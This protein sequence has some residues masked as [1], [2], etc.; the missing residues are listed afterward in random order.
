MENLAE[1]VAKLDALHVDIQPYRPLKPEQM[2]RLMQKLRLDW[3]YHSNHIEGNSLT[4]G[5][6]RTLLL[7]GTTAK[8]KPLKDHLDIQGHNE[9]VEWIM[10][11]LRGEEVERPL[12]ETFIRELHKLILKEPYYKDAITSN[13]LPTKKLIQIG[14][15]KTE[16]N[17]VLTPTGEMFYYASPEE[18]QARM[19]YLMTWYETETKKKE[20][21]PLAIA[22]GFHYRFVRIHPFDDG[23]GRMARLLMNFILMKYGY[24]PAIIPTEQRKEY[25]D[26]L[27]EADEIYNENEHENTSYL[28]PLAIYVGKCLTHSLDLMLKVARGESIEEP[29]DFSKKV[30]LLQARIKANEEIKI[31]KDENVLT[32]LIHFELSKNVKDKIFYKK[33]KELAPLFMECSTSII[34]PDFDNSKLLSDI[35]DIP[36]IKIL[37]YKLS[38]SPDFDFTQKMQKKY[39]NYIEYKFYL[40]NFKK[41]GIKIFN[42]LSFVN[43]RFEEFKYV[44]F[45]GFANTQKTIEK[46]YHQV[47]TEAE[48]EEIANFIGDGLLAEI[49]KRIS[50]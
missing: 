47:P 43:V 41:L 9:A 20:L 46:L 14:Q 26:A 21:H 23:N 12:S 11:L 18:T 37:N 34:F 15:Y 5:E 35:V 49:E 27:R 44:I 50:Q 6:T 40:N 16:P 10:D 36:D 19:G 45:Y 31:S 2:Q 28:V 30:A 29:D 13:G 1:I 38:D 42:L 32:N 48:W 7:Y 4:Y 17:H 25:I 22:V 3:N 33:I 24:P 39:I 8:G